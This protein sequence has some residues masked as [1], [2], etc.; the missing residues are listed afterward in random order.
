MANN[1][2]KSQYSKKR[3]KPKKVDNTTNPFDKELKSQRNKKIVGIVAIVIVVVMVTT[4]FLPYLTGKSD[5]INYQLP[6]EVLK[7]REDTS[8]QTFSVNTISL[9]QTFNRSEKDYYVIFASEEDAMNIQEQ[10]LDKNVYLVNPSLS[11]N[12]SLNEDI[13]KGKKLPKKPSEIKIKDKMAL[14]RIKDN[15]T[16]AFFNTENSVNE[17]LKK[18]K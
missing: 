8:T 3:V 1:K 15:Q 9:G 2:F 17:Y 10:L 12:N 16:K 18:I 13:S 14:I 5:N 6:E 11:V 4:M 7:A